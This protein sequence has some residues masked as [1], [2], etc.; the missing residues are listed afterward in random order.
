MYCLGSSPPSYEN[1]GQALIIILRSNEL[2]LSYYHGHIV[3]YE[4]G[5]VDN[6]FG[7]LGENCYLQLLFTA[8]KRDVFFV[9]VAKRKSQKTGV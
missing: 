2:T 8:D 9:S 4:K 3:S 5:K 7:L 1:E 6:T